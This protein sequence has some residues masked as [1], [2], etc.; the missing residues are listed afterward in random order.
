MRGDCAVRRSQ[1]SLN[2]QYWPTLRG[3][4]PRLGA[5]GVHKKLALLQH[6]LVCATRLVVQI[7]PARAAP[8]SDAGQRPTACAGRGPTAPQ[9]TAKSRSNSW[10]CCLA[11]SSSLFVYRVIA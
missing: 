11:L 10:N 6:V 4:G 9:R 2:I 3:R 5:Q 1:G 7:L 8:V